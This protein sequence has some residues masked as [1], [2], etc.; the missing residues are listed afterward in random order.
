MRISRGILR[1]GPVAVKQG[2][3]G[4]AAPGTRRGNVNVNVKSG[5]SVGWWGGSGCGGRCK[6][7]HVSSV[8]ASMRLTP[9]RP[10]PPRLRQ[11]PATCRRSTPCVDAFRSIVEMFDFDGDSSPTQRESVGGGVV[12]L[13]RTVGAM[14]GAIEP[15][16]TGLR[17]V[18]HSH[19][20]PPSHGKP[21]FAVEV[22]GQR[23]ALPRVQGATLPNPHF[24]QPSISP[25]AN[26][27]SFALTI[28]PC[29]SNST[30]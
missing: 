29:A 19:T 10:D 12:W 8:A 17:R 9:P 28:R 3:I 30:L 1:G 13:C 4:R 14:D 11:I 7:V 6:Y 25:W 16:W 24:T 20:A 22:A 18:L 27:P 15:P 26:G 21:A 2:V 5:L 23:P